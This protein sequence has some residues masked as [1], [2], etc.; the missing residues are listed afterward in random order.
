MLYIPH[1]HPRR[2]QL[3]YAYDFDPDSSTAAAFVVR[4]VE[5]GA[6][7]LEIGAGAGSI[8]R[9]LTEV[10]HAKVT[11]L[12]IDQASADYL[13]TFCERVVRADLNQA[14]W[15]AQ[16]KGEPPYDAVVIADV[17]EHLLDPL[18]TLRAAATLLKPDGAVVVSLPHA[19]HNS[20]LACLLS[21]DFEYREWGLLDK[22]HLRFFGIKN[23]KQLVRDAGLK[24]VDARFVVTSPA[25]TEFKDKW[26]RLPMMLRYSLRRNRYGNVYQVVF[27]AVGANCAPAEMDLEKVSIPNP[28]SIAGWRKKSKNRTAKLMKR[29]GLN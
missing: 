27:K 12:E 14:D 4:F 9:P 10:L 23:V 13:E 21:A 2:E 28:R 8:A 15:T 17:L 7:V 20:V 11:A 19:G 25:K 22:T 24:I 6:R 26:A 3:K 5:S 29:L 1:P 18:S 16:F